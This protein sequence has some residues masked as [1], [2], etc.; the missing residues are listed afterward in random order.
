MASLTR[1]LVLFAVLLAA[2]TSDGYFPTAAPALEPSPAMEPSPAVEVMLL[3]TSPPDPRIG[4][5]TFGTAY[6][7]GTHEIAKPLIRF[8][9]TYPRIVWRADLTRVVSARFVMWTLVRRS[10]SGL[11]E[12]VF[13]VEKPIDDS[14]WTLASSGALTLHV[15]HVAGT[16]VMRYLDRNEI[17]AE[18]TFT[19]VD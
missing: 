7:A 2:C 13:E 15:G 18:G 9:R 5:I 11:E 4:V 14:T 8:Q 3:V 12:T 17:L 19:L 10:D 16:Y 6:D 1:K